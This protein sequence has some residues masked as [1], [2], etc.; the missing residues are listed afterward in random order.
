MIYLILP[1]N[2]TNSTIIQKHLNWTLQNNNT[3]KLVVLSNIGN[4][5]AWGAKKP[6]PGILMGL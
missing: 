3:S 4:S 1:L 5:L 6:G 2:R